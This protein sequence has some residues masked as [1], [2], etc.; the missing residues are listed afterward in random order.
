MGV[1]QPSTIYRYLV[2][3]MAAT[4]LK[5]MYTQVLVW[6]KQVETGAVLS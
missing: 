1:Q 6:L 5:T 3:I 2:M 4:A